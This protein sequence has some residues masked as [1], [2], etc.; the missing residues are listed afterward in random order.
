MSHYPQLSEEEIAAINLQRR[1]NRYILAAIGLVI[2]GLLAVFSPG[3]NWVFLL[4][5]FIVIIGML[6]ARFYLERQA[7]LRRMAQQDKETDREGE[8]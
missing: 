2:L 4:F 7:H 1:R 8:S 3:Y 6:F 5:I